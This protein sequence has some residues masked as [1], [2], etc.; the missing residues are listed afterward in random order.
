VA[1][2]LP[3]GLWNSQR[4]QL[5]NQAVYRRSWGLSASAIEIKNTVFKKDF[6]RSGLLPIQ[7]FGCLIN[8]HSIYLTNK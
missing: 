6:K 2:L 1:G 5:Q 3:A 7:L 4:L 8:N